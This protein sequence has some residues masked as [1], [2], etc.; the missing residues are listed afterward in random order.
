MARSPLLWRRS[1]V[2]DLNRSGLDLMRWSYFDHGA[3][4]L[5]GIQRPNYFS[6][7]SWRVLQLLPKK[8]SPIPTLKCATDPL[9]TLTIS[10]F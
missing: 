3:Q 10:L 7:S 6:K 1:L 8:V 2:A 5:N 9:K 4:D